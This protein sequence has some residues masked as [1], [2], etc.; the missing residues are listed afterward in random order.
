MNFHIT[1]ACPLVVPMFGGRTSPPAVSQFSIGRGQFDHRGEAAC[2]LR[3][4]PAVDVRDGTAGKDKEGGQVWEGKQGFSHTS[5]KQCWSEACQDV[6][7]GVETK[8]ES[9]R[10][11]M[12][13]F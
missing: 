4:S 12:F 6:P 11:G 9:V 7:G 2:V 1:H 10:S 13:V 8:Y 3:L 5:G